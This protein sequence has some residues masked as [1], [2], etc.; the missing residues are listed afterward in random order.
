MA[1]CFFRCHDS[2]PEKFSPAMLA[3]MMLD[4][5]SGSQLLAPVGEIALDGTVPM[6]NC[7]ELP[8]RA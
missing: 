2:V 5:A 6:P 7:P 4:V 3:I 8:G 1:R